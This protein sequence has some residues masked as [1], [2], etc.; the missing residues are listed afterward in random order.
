MKFNQATLKKQINRN[1]Y[2]DRCANR[3]MYKVHIY[4]KGK[5]AAVCGIAVAPGLDIVS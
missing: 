1:T 2:R 4:L 5:S 3:S